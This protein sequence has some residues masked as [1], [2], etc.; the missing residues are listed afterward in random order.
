M[1]KNERCEQS[2]SVTSDSSFHENDQLTL[3]SN[4]INI[5]K[6]TA[7]ECDDCGKVEQDAR[8]KQSQTSNYNSE[9]EAPHPIKSVSAARKQYL[10]AKTMVDTE[11]PNSLCS[12][13]VTT[14][15]STFEFG[16]HWQ[17]HVSKGDIRGV[18]AL[19]QGVSP[20]HIPVLLGNK[21]EGAGVGCALHA[22]RHLVNIQADLAYQLLLYLTRTPRFQ[23]LC[24]GQLSLLSNHWRPKHPGLTFKHIGPNVLLCF[25]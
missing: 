22:L 16:Q 19:L 9:I 23:I 14:E 5:H 10:N 12:T 18:A 6:E 25:R 4:M 1:D 2:E 11:E 24:H 17:W 21:L 8:E 3:S 13:N 20:S 7:K 15:L